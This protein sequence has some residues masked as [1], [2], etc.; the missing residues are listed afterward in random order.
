MTG[1]N[2]AENFA[3]ITARNLSFLVRHF[4]C[5]RMFNANLT[6]EGLPLLSFTISVGPFFSAKSPG[7]GLYAVPDDTT[8]TRHALCELY[9]TSSRAQKTTYLAR[10]SGDCRSVNESDTIASQKN[11]LRNYLK[12]DGLIQKK[13]I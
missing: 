12:T 8:E 11:S 5:L 1:L 2:M 13:A 4:P 10:V 7:T 6:G 9:G 3:S